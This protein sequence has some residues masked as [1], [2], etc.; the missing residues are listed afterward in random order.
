[1]ARHRNPFQTAF[2]HHPYFPAIINRPFLDS[3]I[4]VIQIAPEDYLLFQSNVC[5]DIEQLSFTFPNLNIFNGKN[6]YY[7]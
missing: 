2:P 6:C 7:L 3:R 1:M 5:L 4:L